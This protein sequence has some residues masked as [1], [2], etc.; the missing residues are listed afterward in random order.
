[1]CFKGIVFY[2]KNE[3]FMLILFGNNFKILI[4]KD[5]YCMLW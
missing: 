4:F 2:D 5:F 3:D 1:M